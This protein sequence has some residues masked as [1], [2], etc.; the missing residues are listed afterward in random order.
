MGSR[1]GVAGGAQRPWA[2]LPAELM[3]KMARAAPAGDRLLFRL[4]RRSWAA[5]KTGIVPAAGKKP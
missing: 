2:D 5:A 3:E 4:A 1:Q